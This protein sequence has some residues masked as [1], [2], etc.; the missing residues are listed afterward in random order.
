M[1]AKDVEAT[2]ILTLIFHGPCRPKS[3]GP[4]PSCSTTS[5]NAFQYGLSVLV[6]IKNIQSTPRLS[7]PTAFSANHGGHLWDIRLYPRHQDAEDSMERVATKFETIE[8]MI[9]R[10]QEVIV[11]LDDKLLNLIGGLIGKLTPYETEGGPT[12]FYTGN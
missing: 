9:D 8:N 6:L 10:M 11:A 4:L 1:T 5:P 2:R 12:E 7:K 3:I